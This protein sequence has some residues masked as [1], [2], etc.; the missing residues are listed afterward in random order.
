MEMEKCKL[1]FGSFVIGTVAGLQIYAWNTG[2]DGQVFA[3]TSLIIGGIAGY[4]FGF[5]R[6]V[7]TTMQEIAHKN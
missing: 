4:V 6:K 5:T 3:L 1:L 7:K 2:H